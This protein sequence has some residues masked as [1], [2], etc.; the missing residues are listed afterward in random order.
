MTR[1][2]I[3]ALGAAFATGACGMASTTTDPPLRSDA[4]SGAAAAR[5]A[6]TA[7][8]ARPSLRPGELLRAATREV[9][10]PAGTTLALVLKSGL[11]SDTSAVEDRISAELVRP[12]RIGGFEVLPA[13]TQLTGAITEVDAS[14]RLNG[15]AMI[16]FRFTSLHLGDAQY[17][18]RAVPLSRVAAATRGADTTRIGLGAGAGTGGPAPRGRA[19]RLGPGADVTTRLVSPL[20]VRVGAR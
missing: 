5:D 2:L 7:P 3:V 10:I 16:A 12:I 4:G 19:V 8:A 13:G 14:G 6:A 20:T 15:G 9:T 17:D 11:A 1:C 18:V